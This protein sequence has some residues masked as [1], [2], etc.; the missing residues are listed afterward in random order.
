MGYFDGLIASGFK[1]LDDGRFVYYPYG[2]FGQ[3]YIISA[4]DA[5]RIRRFVRLNLFIFPPIF[6]VAFYLFRLY[7]LV[8]SLLYILFYYYKIHGLLANSEKT[9]DRMSYREN[10]RNV[11]ISMGLPTCLIFFFLSLVMTI[12]SIIVLLMTEGGVIGIFSTLFFGLAF[13][14][15]FFMVEYAIDRER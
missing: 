14:Q 2:I 15:Y 11:A 12:A 8:A 13:L 7:G 4:D 6:V 5:T 3:G 1:K 10:L 9:H